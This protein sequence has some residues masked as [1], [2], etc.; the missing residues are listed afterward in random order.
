MK[1]IEIT[2]NI[3]QSNKLNIL[4]ICLAES[5]WLSQTLYQAVWVF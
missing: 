3:T 2:Y 1:K 4:G 5:L